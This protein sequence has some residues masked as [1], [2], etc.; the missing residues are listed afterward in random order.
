MLDKTTG[1]IWMDGKLVDCT[2]ANI[3]V[4]SH[5]LHYGSGVFEGER[6]YGGK[7]FKMEEHHQ[8]FHASAAWLDFTIP[9]CVAELNH[10]AETV[11]KVNQLSDA[12]VR[13]VAWHGSE[14]K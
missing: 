3:H 6:A 9:Y 12:Y 2:E 4:L 10:A 7:I 5:T 8:R 14:S 11:I 1:K 13:P